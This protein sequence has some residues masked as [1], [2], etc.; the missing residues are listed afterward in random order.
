LDATG[1][2]ASTSSD[3]FE[4]PRPSH[5]TLQRLTPTDD[6]AMKKVQN[7]KDLRARGWTEALIRDFL[8]DPDGT[9][10]VA[11]WANY[12]GCD[13]WDSHRV[14][15]EEKTEEFEQAL[16]RSLKRRRKSQSEKRKMMRLRKTRPNLKVPARSKIDEAIRL[17]AGEIESARRRGFRT[18]HK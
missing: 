6:P 15:A 9:S 4:A 1:A 18:P 8:G 2:V 16:G 7:R 14:I 11:H 3:C 17:A 12:R 5:V 13:H 10:S